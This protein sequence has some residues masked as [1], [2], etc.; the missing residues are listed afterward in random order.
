M[1]TNFSS[2]LSA[3]W[4]LAE[5][6]KMK[7]VRPS[8]DQK[9]N[10]P[11]KMEGIASQNYRIPQTDTKVNKLNSKFSSSSEHRERKIHNGKNL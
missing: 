6:E 8:E 1:T 5:E 10:E 9:K 7:W 2:G 4:F 11:Q 3:V